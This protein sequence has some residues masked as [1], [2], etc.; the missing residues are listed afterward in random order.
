[1]W[2]RRRDSNPAPATSC[3]CRSSQI[4][5]R[6][7]FICGSGKHRRDSGRQKCQGRKDEVS[8]R[9]GARLCMA[10]SPA[11]SLLSQIYTGSAFRAACFG[12]SAARIGPCLIRC[13]LLSTT[14]TPWLLL[15]AI[16]ALRVITLTPNSTILP[17][18]HH[19]C[20]RLSTVKFWIRL[21]PM[22][23]PRAGCLPGIPRSGPA[24]CHPPRSA[25]TVQL[26][27]L[28]GVMSDSRRYLTLRALPSQEPPYQQPSSQAL[29]F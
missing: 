22:S 4:L 6:E 14:S 10:A 19:R 5:S 29:H 25:R 9:A 27:S 20:R 18:R 13:S 21:L 15:D 23:R 17:V 11:R 8:R 24:S 26:S 7:K 1:M 28:D 12:R 3:S 16:H 2:M